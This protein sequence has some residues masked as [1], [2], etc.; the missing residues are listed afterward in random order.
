MFVAL[1]KNRLRIVGP[2]RLMPV[3]V[4][5]RFSLHSVAHVAR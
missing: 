4:A 5:V 2:E 3:S 1:D